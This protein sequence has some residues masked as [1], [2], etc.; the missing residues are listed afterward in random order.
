[1]CRAEGG[2]FDTRRTRQMHASADEGT[3]VTVEAAIF[4]RPFVVDIPVPVITGRVCLACRN[5]IHPDAPAVSA[6]KSDLV[7]ARLHAAC[8]RDEEGDL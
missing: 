6:G 5:L 1:M 4:G 3:P 7:A 2:S 8:A